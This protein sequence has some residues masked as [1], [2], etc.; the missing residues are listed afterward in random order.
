VDDAL[1]GFRPFSLGGGRFEQPADGVGFPLDAVVELARYERLLIK[2]AR[3]LWLA[4]HEGRVRVPKGFEEAFK[5]RLTGV[6]HGSVSPVVTV[7]NP[8]AGVLFA[9]P[10]VQ[11]AHG[12]IA[13][14]L[15]AVVS[16]EPL[17]GSFPDDAVP[18]LVPFGSSFAEGETCFVHRPQGSDVPY[19]QARRK[20]LVRIV[21]ADDIKFDGHLVGRV[22]GFE[23]NQQTF[24]FTGR[25]GRRTQGAFEQ[26]GMIDVWKK[27]A[28]RD[29][30]APFVRLSC[31][32][33]TTETG[34]LSRIEDV[35]DVEL[36]VGHAD[37]LAGQL[38]PLLE[39]QGAWDGREAPAPALAAIAWARDFATD[40]N[41]EEAARFAVFPTHEGGVLVEHHQDGRR[42]SLDIDSDGNAITV[43]V[44][45]ELA[46]TLDEIATP[47][48][49]LTQFREFFA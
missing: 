19:T 2:V 5:L 14:A 25:D 47:E 40:L 37:R 22:A 28:D 30:R 32:Y 18:L 7:Q 33:A 49:A 11:R 16:E 29:A 44:D 12:E 27:Y 31:R 20:H 6:E 17:P 1:K 8:E 21:S 35:D 39:L 23:A 36:F 26:L 34:F 10:M 15:A 4:E 48:A 9:D 13:G 38:R 46:S 45:Q 24:T 41:E 42:W 3:E 43:T